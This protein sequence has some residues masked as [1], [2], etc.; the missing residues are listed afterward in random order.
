MTTL[1]D[2]NATLG[3]QNIALSE[4]AKAQKQTNTGISEF[5]KH[6]KQTDARDRRED[7]EEKRESKKASVV[8]SKLA[9]AGAAAGS[10]LGSA[11]RGLLNVGRKGFNITKS[12]L[13]SLRGLGPGFLGGLLSSRLIRF[14]I[15][16]L[17]LIFG[18]EIADFILGPDGSGELKKQLS[19][20]IKGGAI[21]SL[22][23]PRFALLGTAIGGLLA[24]EKVDRELG[25]LVTNIDDLAKKL[26]LKDGLAGLFKKITEG[27]GIGLESLN[28]LLG[29]QVNLENIVKGG[30]LIGGI[31]TLLMPGKLLGMAFKAGKLLL[32]TPIGRAI[33]FAAGGFKLIQ[34]I[35][36]SGGQTGNDARFMTGPEGDFDY[37]KQAGNIEAGKEKEKMKIPG[38]GGEM[39]TLDQAIAGMM[40]GQLVFSGGKF[41]ANKMKTPSVKPQQSI[42]NLFNNVKTKQPPNIFQRMMNLV[43]TGGRHA[44][45]LVRG[46]PVLLPLAAVAGLTAVLNNKESSQ[47]LAMD[48]R[49]NKLKGTMTQQGIDAGINETGGG[50]MEM[51]L[52]KSKLYSDSPAFKPLGGGQS[53]TTLSEFF[54]RNRNSSTGYK[55]SIMSLVDNSN[56]NNVTTNQST[57]ALFGN[58]VQVGHDVGDQLRS[59]FNALKF[60]GF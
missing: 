59:E 25:K 51:I 48:T 9:A 13:S 17:A 35:L 54:A 21:G 50:G 23:G 60:Q 3:V 41:I 47:K 39:S 14:G 43:K 29:G 38:F 30:T 2:V 11:G 4:V 20:A 45:S 40:A 53:G 12:G 22:L 31:A 19:G 37:N 27:V 57:A 36:N 28:K 58:A 49:A 42:S 44:I 6:M 15:P 18:D 8:G 24:D 56:S 5:L 34:G 52:P 26:G 55:D 16:G 10:G 32:M 33:L 7:N 1:A 46:L